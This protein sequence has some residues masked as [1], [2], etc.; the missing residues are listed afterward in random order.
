MREE[1]ARILRAMRNLPDFA[2]SDLS[3]VNAC[4]VDGDNALHVAVLW[5]DLQ[6]AEALI[7]AGVDINE[8]GDLGYT[9]LHV[10]CMRGSMEMVRLL[11][12]NGADLFALSE[13]APPFAAAR[14]AGRDDVCDLLKPL[15]EQVQSQDPK[16]WA[17]A[18]I[19]RLR[20]EIASLEHSLES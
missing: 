9:P 8:A 13:G 7:D 1:A 16:T 4:G 6:G 11:V 15:M 10:A 2:E 18:R 20:R 12:A 19:A 3:D 17:R 14:L 5:D